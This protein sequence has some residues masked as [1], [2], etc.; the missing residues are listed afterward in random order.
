MRIV[1][2][3]DVGMTADQRVRLESLGTVSWYESST[4]TEALERTSNADVVLVDWIDPSPFILNM[5]RHSMV[6]L[7]ST[8]YSWIKNRSEAK[9]R[10]IIIAN[11]PGYATEAVAEHL[12]CLILCLA[13]HMI[14]F[15]KDLRNG[16]EKKGVLTALELFGKQIGIIGVG[17]IG[18]RLAQMAN[19]MGMTVCGYSRHPNTTAAI[20]LVTLDELIHTSDVVAVCC[21]FN[22]DSKNLLNAER[23]SK[24]KPN[25]IVVSATLDVICLEDAIP[26]LEE[27][28]IYGMGL[29]VAVEGGNIVLPSKLLSLDNVV[30]TPHVAYNTEEAKRRQMDIAISNIENFLSGHPTNVVC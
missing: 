23:L 16:N 25:A 1:V 5:K 17:R 26:V 8:G 6:A 21:P 22:D 14:P 11:V 28:K 24:L 3:E 27:K 7:L 4:E 15:D 10:D 20:D 29:D 12:L 9:T 19:S 30:L 2:L 13:R 18:R